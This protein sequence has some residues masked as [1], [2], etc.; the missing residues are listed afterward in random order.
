MGLGCDEGA[1]D[2]D[3]LMSR[4]APKT[5]GTL[6]LDPRRAFTASQRLV[7]FTTQ[8]GRCAHCG[9]PL[10]TWECD[11]VIP[12][13]QGGRTVV[14]NGEALCEPCHARKTKRDITDAARTKRL[15][16]KHAGVMKR[17]IRRK[18]VS[19]GFAKAYRPF[20]KKP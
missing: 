18:I 6:E 14:D 16:K 9:T 1:G 5:G 11:H 17:K 7:I 20:R 4:V 10:S 2:E 3:A 19:R 15:Q 8:Q 12:H 13:N